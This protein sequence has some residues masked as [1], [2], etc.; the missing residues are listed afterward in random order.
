[1]IARDAA[2]VA[3]MYVDRI[4]FFAH[5]SQ[6]YSTFQLPM[7]RELGGGAERPSM[8]RMSGSLSQLSLLFVRADRASKG[9][10]NRTTTPS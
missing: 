8:T 1:V 5:V 6:I 3:A 4:E 10:R 9:A 7:F 2:I